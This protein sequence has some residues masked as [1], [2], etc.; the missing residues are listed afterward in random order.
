MRGPATHKGDTVDTL[1]RSVLASEAALLR[2]PKMGAEVATLLCDLIFSGRL[3]AG[4]RL[5]LQDLA[6]ALGVSTTPIREAFLMLEKEGLIESER[7][8]GFRVK[9]L[10]ERDVAD[11]YELHAFLAGLLIERATDCLTDGDLE[12]LAQLDE[13]IGRAVAAREPDEVEQHNFDFH[14]LINRRAPESD[15]LRGKLRETTRYVPRH[16]YKEIPGWLDKTAQDHRSILDALRR[17][18]SQA[19]AGAM[20]T[21][22]RAAGELLVRHLRESGFW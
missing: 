22:I 19:A 14:R 20:V 15:L 4:E 1:V 12:S 11:V 5:R 9:R 3:R 21:H 6:E 7:H 17:R 16:F 2:S 8:R 18:D 13:Q 10:T